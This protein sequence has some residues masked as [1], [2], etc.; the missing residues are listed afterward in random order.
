MIKYINEVTRELGIE[1]HTLRNWEDKG[2]LGIVERDFT[3]GRMYMEEQIERIKVI[4]QV[5]KEQQERGMKRT[6]FKEVERVLFERFGGMIEEKVPSIPATPE[7]FTNMVLKM[8]KQDQQIQQLQ[9]MVLELT[10]V[11][12]QIPSSVDHTNEINEIKENIEGVMTKT[13]GEELLSKLVDKEKRE[14]DL[15]NEVEL[16]KE[17]LDIAVDYIQR[18]ENEEKK[19]GFF[20]RLFG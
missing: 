17:K 15:K 7:V 4:Q 12:K 14:K 13:Q 1:H 18:Q 8:E 10:N 6:D 3:H 2:Y 5:V 16:L 19:K 20:K 9:Q 11:A